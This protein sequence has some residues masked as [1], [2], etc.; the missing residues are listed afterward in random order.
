M[1]EPELFE[2]I[3]IMLEDFHMGLLLGDWYGLKVAA[4]AEK[5]TIEEG[6]L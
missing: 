3:Q 5:K 2:V 6:G 1:T 4:W